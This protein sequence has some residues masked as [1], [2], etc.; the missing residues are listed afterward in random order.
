MP[1]YTRAPHPAARLGSLPGKVPYG[2]SYR[3]GVYRGGYIRGV[4]GHGLPVVLLP[5]LPPDQSSYP[6]AACP[7]SPFL[8][9]M[10][11]YVCGML[12]GMYVVGIHH[13]LRMILLHLPLPPPLQRKRHVPV[14][15]RRSVCPSSLTGRQKCGSA[16]PPQ[17][18]SPGITGRVCTDCVHRWVWRLG[19]SQTTLFPDPAGDSWRPDLGSGS[20]SW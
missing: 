9:C 20:R 18:V 5:T 8:P 12:L 7:P 17:V 19:G 11:R 14:L 13:P 3:G 4:Y 6:P 10:S 2:G 1:A 15:L 16:E